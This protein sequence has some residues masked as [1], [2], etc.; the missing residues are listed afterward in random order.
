MP[1]S[2]SKDFFQFWEKPNL[3]QRKLSCLNLATLIL[4]QFLLRINKN[5][6]FSVFL[7]V[8]S[9]FPVESPIRRWAFHLPRSVITT[10]GG[11]ASCT[12]AHIQVSS[13]VGSLPGKLD[14][15]GS[16]RTSSV[17]FAGKDAGHIGAASHLMMESSQSTTESIGG[18]TPAR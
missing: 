13:T 7:A 16:C 4:T 12:K 18:M 1:R 2:G 8:K 17:L 3:Q 5:F 14:W 15:H 10:Y 6:D 11:S 9:F